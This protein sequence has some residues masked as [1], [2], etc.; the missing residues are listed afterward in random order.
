[1]E[2]PKKTYY[3]NYHVMKHKDEWD[4]HTRRVIE[5]RAQTK[6]STFFTAEERELLA[7]LVHHLF[8]SH[9]GEKSIDVV[10]LFD[11]HC[12]K[13]YLRGYR[14]GCRHTKLT[15]IHLGLKS[16]QSHSLEAY[17][18]PFLSLKKAEQQHLIE[19]WMNNKGLKNIWQNVAPYT[20]MQTLM[21]ELISIVYSDPSVWSAIGYGG[22]AYPHG[23]YAFGPKQFDKW[24]A[25]VHDKPSSR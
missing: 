22:P 11:E 15:I 8:P 24:E 21:D 12:A 7:D 18:Q 23:Y 13:G 16:I 4:E 9:L 14:K 25:P 17:F 3:P 2:H 1:M 10:S 20:F 6:D 5:S 19:E